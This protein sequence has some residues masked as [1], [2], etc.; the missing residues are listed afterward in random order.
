MKIIHGNNEVDLPDFLLAGSAKCGT[1]TIFQ[2]LQRQ[3][4]VFL[5]ELKE[6]FY[7]SFGNEK[8]TYTDARFNSKVIWK[9]EEYLALFQNA[10][11]TQLIGDASTS[12]LY[13]AEKTIQ[14]VK[15]LYK[16]KASDLKIIVI[17]R[18]PTE[19][20]FSH[21]THLIRNG[22]E[23]LNFSEAITPQNIEQRSRE[24]WGFDYTGYG[25]YGAQMEVFKNFFKHILVLDYEE[26]SQ[27]NQMMEKIYTFLDI[28]NPVKVEEKIEANPSGVPKSKFV[29]ALIRSKRFKKILKQITP[30][31]ALP[32]FQKMK[33][34]LLKKS[35]VKPKIS[36]Q[37]NQYLREFF[38][39]D[40]E[41]L[42]RIL[43]KNFNSWK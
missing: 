27:P 28:K 32:I 11:S 26:L 10:K 3:S 2:Y 38:R 17:L 25:M 31:K 37:D 23:K 15:S 16:E 21:Y 5:P 39:K 8:P 43:N 41:Q 35:I 24:M 30:S 7:F 9:T 6:P 4:S 22:I 29:T 13:T 12:Y 36:E 19:R 33:D 1:T 40:I 20:A 34:S 14:N 18:N 42:E